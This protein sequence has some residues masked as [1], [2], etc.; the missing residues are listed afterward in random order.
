[1]PKNTYSYK[2]IPER[3]LDHLTKQL[4]TNP[5]WVEI[6]N[7]Q[8]PTAN[9]RVC[10]DSSTCEEKKLTNLGDNPL[11]KTQI[12]N[13]KKEQQKLA[14][15][16]EKQ[17]KEAEEREK[18]DAAQRNKATHNIHCHIVCEADAQAALKDA[19][20]SN[21]T[22][23]KEGYQLIQKQIS[24]ELVNVYVNFSGWASKE[25]WQE[26]HFGVG[27]R[28]QKADVAILLAPLEREAFGNESSNKK[29]KGSGY[30]EPN[31]PIG[32]DAPPKIRE[33]LHY[34]YLPEPCLKILGGTQDKKTNPATQNNFSHLNYYS[35]KR[36]E[37]VGTEIDAHKTVTTPIVLEDTEALRNS[38]QVDAMITA[39]VIPALKAKKEK[40]QKQLMTGQPRNNITEALKLIKEQVNQPQWNQAGRGWFFIGHKTPRH[41]QKIREL[42]KKSL[43]KI[44][45]K[46]KES[47]TFGQS[48]WNDTGAT[49]GQ[50]E[51]A[52]RQ[53]GEMQ[54][55]T[56]I[57]LTK[58]LIN[59]K[60]SVSP[61]RSRETQALYENLLTH[62]L[63]VL[64]MTESRFR[65][66]HM[67]PASMLPRC[68]GGR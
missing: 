59:A 30:W 15:K 51:N 34:L 48:L 9:S 14:A 36:M 38:G 32:S 10:V 62:M 54:E 61:A 63:H 52:S 60:D 53:L 8:Q 31:G 44:E 43:D 29:L 6:P 26:Q 22:S 25:K 49:A 1:M 39:A 24:G 57:A 45:R 42:A 20:H 37:I 23:D 13:W 3:F 65:T 12:E 18:K 46:T 58:I 21:L 28:H 5:V 67:Q 47:E 56:A 27:A 7:S 4:M 68:L 19:I 55:N 16:Q 11:L 40:E 66:K 33:E 2:N 50:V 41:I 64:D 17:K 35:S